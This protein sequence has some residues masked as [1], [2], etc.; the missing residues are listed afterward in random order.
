MAGCVSG[1]GVCGMCVE[2][3]CVSVCVCLWVWECV[4]FFFVRVSEPHLLFQHR[5]RPTSF[6]IDFHGGHWEEPS[7]CMCQLGQDA[8]HNVEHGQPWHDSG[9]DREEERTN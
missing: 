6:P 7:P 8:Q 9:G 4:C 2:C 3:V 1:C 5:S